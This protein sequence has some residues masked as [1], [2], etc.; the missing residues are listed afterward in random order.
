M[1]PP[2]LV[3]VE[4][5]FLPFFPL[6]EL[7]QEELTLL[8][9]R[10]NLTTHCRVGSTGMMEAD[11][12]AASLLSKM[13]S[14]PTTHN[15]MLR[16]QAVSNMM[17]HV[18]RGSPMLREQ[19]VRGLA[20]IANSP[21]AGEY[22]TPNSPRVGF[23]VTHPACLSFSIVWDNIY[24]LCQETSESRSSFIARVPQIARKNSRTVLHLSRR[25]S[26]LTQKDVFYLSL[27]QNLLQA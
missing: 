12:Y 21:Q 14:D 3:W 9:E 5:L 19:A 20:S 6:K 13:A 2:W 4:F 24:S 10:V 17:S 16:S 26:V 7:S 23:S 22:S 8:R 25:G 27:L 18:A 1:R 11:E 15:E